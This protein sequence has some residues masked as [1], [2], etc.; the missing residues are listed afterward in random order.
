[1]KKIHVLLFVF[2]LGCSGN[3]IQEYIPVPDDFGYRYGKHN[4]AYSI[5]FN[6]PNIPYTP[7]YVITFYDL[8]SKDCHD[9]EIKVH[10]MTKDLVCQNKGHGL[11]LHM[12]QGCNNGWGEVVRF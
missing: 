9:F 2:I 3:P 8:Q 5:F 1:M 10:D 12:D 4:C 7:V 6:Q 11:I